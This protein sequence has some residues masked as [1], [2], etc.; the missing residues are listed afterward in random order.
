MYSPDGVQ[1]SEIQKNYTARG[2]WQG[3][4]APEPF[5]VEDYTTLRALVAI[6][7]TQ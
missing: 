4:F 1:L 2:L 7:T 6:S 3:V 5:T